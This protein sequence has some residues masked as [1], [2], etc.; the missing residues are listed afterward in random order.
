MLFDV[1]NVA[2]AVP[3]EKAFTYLTDITRLPEWT[4]AFARVEKDG[5]ALM[6]TPE[7]EVNVILEDNVDR[8]NGII[9]TKMIFPDGGIGIA[10]SRLIALTDDSCAYSFILTPPP[11]ALEA[12]EGALSEQSEILEQELQTLKSRLEG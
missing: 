6:R 2:L 3:F 4:N 11:L 5:N 8:I 7:G 9:D 12:M 1:K 10:Y